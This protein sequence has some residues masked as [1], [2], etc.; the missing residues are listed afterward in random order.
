MSLVTKKG[1]IE[2]APK[3]P[4]WVL[5][6]I[7]KRLKEFNMFASF[8]QEIKYATHLM[9]VDSPSLLEEKKKKK[10]MEEIRISMNFES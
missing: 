8:E 1:E 10:K 9:D 4:S 7:D 2:D 3:S 5:V 6:I